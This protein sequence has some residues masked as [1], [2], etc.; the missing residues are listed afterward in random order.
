[1]DAALEA[2]APARPSSPQGVVIRTFER[3]RDDRAVHATLMEAFAKH[4]AFAE[5]PF[6]EWSA[7]T[8]DRETF[9]PELWFVADAEKD[10][11]GSILGVV[12]LDMG[13]IADIGVRQG[14]RGRGI[15]EAL[16]R[17]SLESF[18][19]RGFGSVGLNV[20]PDNE[21]G[22]MRLYERLGFTFERQYEFYELDL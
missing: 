7:T 15:G 13:W 6:E 17:R 16:V 4:Y 12:R 8:I 20:D 2:G 14:W 10:V 19:A 5:I 11:V 18:R 9:D 22:A 21:T 3:E 1:M